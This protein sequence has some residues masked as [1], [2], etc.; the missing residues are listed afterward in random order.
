MWTTDALT[1]KSSILAYL[2]TD[3][4]YAAYAIGDLEPGMFEQCAWAGAAESGQIRALALHFRGLAIPALFLMGAPEG[5]RAIFA[6]A[7]RPERVYLTC[8]E[9]HLPVTR[10][11]YEWDFETPMW[12]MA[13]NAAS[14]RPIDGEPVRLRP[15]DAGALLALFA[16]GGGDA[17]TPSQMVHGVFYGMLVDDRLVAVAGTHLVS[18]TYG[19]GAVGNVFTHPDYRGRGY[20]TVTTSAVVAELLRGGIRD[21]VLNVSQDNADAIR[22]YERLGFARYCPFLEGTAAAK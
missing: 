19:V 5:L 13:L 14:F 10:D 9:A 4:L 17:F 3:Q 22:I 6:H 8:L 15:D 12:R 21:V 7:L 2:E 1:D 11:F 18:P 16:L 20:G